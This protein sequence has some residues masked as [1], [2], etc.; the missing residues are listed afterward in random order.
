MQYRRGRSPPLPGA[1][2]LKGVQIETDWDFIVQ[3][4]A[5]SRV[6]ITIT[7]LVYSNEA[8]HIDH[9]LVENSADTFSFQENASYTS[10]FVPGMFYEVLDAKNKIFLIGFK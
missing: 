3:F 5:A 9:M 10:S 2:N 4:V 1:S 7:R 6:A 8:K